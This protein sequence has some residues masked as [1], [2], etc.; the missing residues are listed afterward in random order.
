MRLGDRRH[1]DSAL[2]QIRIVERRGKHGVEH[3]F[4]VDLVADDPEIVAARDLADL[5]DFG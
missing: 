1:D 4:L 3:Q 5:G 2:G